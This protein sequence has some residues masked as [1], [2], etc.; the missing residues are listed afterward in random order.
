[1]LES[2]PLHQKIF[3][4]GAFLL[5]YR[6]F[7]LLRF[8]FYFYVQTIVYKG[9]LL[10]MFWVDVEFFLHPTEGK[11][12]GCLADDLPQKKFAFLAKVLCIVTQTK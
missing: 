6:Y 9:F 11:V 10:Q 5:F 8:K 3:L 1:M 12:I 4:F 7:F 2:R